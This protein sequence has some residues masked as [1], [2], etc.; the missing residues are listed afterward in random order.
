MYW[1]R[2]T[3]DDRLRA[4][5]TPPV[6]P[7]PPETLVIETERLRIRPYSSDDLDIGIAILTDDRVTRYVCDTQTPD[8][9]K[10]D[11]P[12]AT[13]R[14]AG[15]RIGI[16]TLIRRDTGDKIG[17][18]VLLPMPVEEDDT[19][20]SLVVPER[21]PDAEIEVGYMLIPSAW[22]QGFATEACTA[23]LQ[24][25]FTHTALDEIVACTDI[26]N[27]VSKRVLRKSGMRPT[28]PRPGYADTVE[29]FS[30]SRADWTART[31]TVRNNGA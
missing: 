21:Y 22:G 15:G 3:D 1:L 23:L 27:G 11:M 29:G 4:M 30:L 16:W 19:D 5:A 6:T 12:T 28:G 13:S 31:S 7:L 17:T 9:V 8:Q 18:G 14:G 25:G 2:W 24:F 26:E 10:A 20:W